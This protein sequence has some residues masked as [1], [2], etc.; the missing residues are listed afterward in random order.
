MALEGSGWRPGA[1][2]VTAESYDRQDF[3]GADPL[4]V[5]RLASLLGL[6][7]KAASA[8]MA[9]F[10]RLHGAVADVQPAPAGESWGGEG[11]ASGEAVSP[12]D[13]AIVRRIRERCPDSRYQGG[14]DEELIQLFRRNKRVLDRRR[15]RHRGHDAP[16]VG[17][18]AWSVRRYDF[19]VLTLTSTSVAVPRAQVVLRRG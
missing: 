3:D 4:Y 7:S 10:H 1:G 5:E 13:A 6:T 9:A 8:A 16:E 15:G 18:A 17:R 19:L 12:Q 14:S 11:T 2:P